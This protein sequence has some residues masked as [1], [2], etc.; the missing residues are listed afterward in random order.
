[1]AGIS[2]PELGSLSCD[3]V[4]RGCEEVEAH[5][6]ICKVSETEEQWEGLFIEISNRQ[7]SLCKMDS[8]GAHGRAFACVWGGSGQI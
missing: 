6:C 4:D 8:A 1:V 2:S 3:V 7:G 5:G